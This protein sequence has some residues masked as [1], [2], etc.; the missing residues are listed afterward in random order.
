MS[1]IDCWISL[2]NSIKQTDK[3]RETVGKQAKPN[4]KPAQPNLRIAAPPNPLQ[5]ANF[6]RFFSAGICSRLRKSARAGSGSQG[7][8]VDFLALSP[9]QLLLKWM[10]RQSC[11]E[12]NP[13]LSAPI[14]RFFERMT[15]RRL[16]KWW[17]GLRTNSKGAGVDKL[18]TSPLARVS[19]HP[20]YEPEP[21]HAID[22]AE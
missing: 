2:R 20:P 13:P 17:V 10:A 22:W 11:T 6:G 12:S 15:S 9:I 21:G 1:A 5:P 14:R 8:W 18:C 7:G 4:M 19:T 3:A 16:G